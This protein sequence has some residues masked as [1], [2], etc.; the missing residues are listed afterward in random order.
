MGVT[1]LNWPLAY[2]WI[3]T[4]ANLMKQYV[5]HLRATNPDVIIDDESI[6]KRVYSI[7]QTPFM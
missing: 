6:K 7:D 1:L 2:F 5:M 3:S 4:P